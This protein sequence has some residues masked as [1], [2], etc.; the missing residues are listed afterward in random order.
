MS[1]VASDHAHPDRPTPDRTHPDRAG[2]DLPQMSSRRVRL[3][4]ITD[5]DS[6][7][8]YELM[9]SP[10]AGGRVRL[11]HHGMQPNRPFPR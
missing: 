9:T 1:T 6:T 11:V 2:R 4:T 7:F 10:E 3:R 8:L 5:R